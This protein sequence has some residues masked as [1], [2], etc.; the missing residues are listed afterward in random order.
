M[1]GGTGASFNLPQK[2]PNS[3]VRIRFCSRYVIMDS[4]PG[5][6]VNSTSIKQIKD[7]F[8]AKK[9]FKTTHLRGTSKILQADLEVNPTGA[10]GQEAR[11]A[12]ESQQQRSQGVTKHTQLPSTE[13]GSS[14]KKT[15]RELVTE[16]ASR[17]L[18]RWPLISL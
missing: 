5:Y 10:T 14:K 9:G 4:I 15:Q 12:E 13:A 18:L 3:Y 16:V 8:Q 6:N 1:A 2:V 17:E 11:L 7:R